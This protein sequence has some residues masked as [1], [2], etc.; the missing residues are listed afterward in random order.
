[1]RMAHRKPVVA[2]RAGGLPDKVKPGQNGWLVE[3][4]NRRRWPAR[5]ATRSTRAAGSPRW[6]TAAA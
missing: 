6:A 1:M 2:T 5:F 4:D 3:P